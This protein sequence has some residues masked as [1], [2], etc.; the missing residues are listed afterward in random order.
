MFF[1]DLGKLRDPVVEEAQ[2]LRQRGF[3]G[4]LLPDGRRQCPLRVAGVGF[5]DVRQRQG[6]GLRRKFSRHLDMRGDDFQIGRLDGRQ[7]LFR[8]ADRL[9]LIGGFQAYALALFVDLIPEVVGAA[10]L[11]LIDGAGIEFDAVQFG[12]HFALSHSLF[13]VSIS[14]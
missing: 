2:K 6:F 9:F 3:V 5:P 10:L 11:R 12:I 14:V 1:G 8:F 4:H 13:P 7:K